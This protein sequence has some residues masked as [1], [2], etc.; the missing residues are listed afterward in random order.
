MSSD[1]LSPGQPQNL[2]R[3]DQRTGHNQYHSPAYVFQDR[4]ATGQ[5]PTIFF[6]FLAFA[7]KSSYSPPYHQ[8][9][10]LQ[11][12]AVFV[13]KQFL[14]E[15]WSRGNFNKFIVGEVLHFVMLSPHHLLCLLTQSIDRDQWS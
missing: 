10:T 14:I 8:F 11:P 9:P 3:R 12:N 15:I 13:A 2:A 4:K 1:E 5:L 7:P 6:H